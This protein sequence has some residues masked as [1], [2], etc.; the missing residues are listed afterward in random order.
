MAS[1]IRITVPQDVVQRISS[2]ASKLSRIE[3]RKYLIDI[4]VYFFLFP[5]LIILSIEFAQCHILCSYFC[6]KLAQRANKAILVTRLT[7]YHRLTSSHTLAQLCY[8]SICNYLL[9][10]DVLSLSLSLSFLSGERLWTTRR[11]KNRELVASEI[12]RRVSKTIQKKCRLKE[13]C[14]IYESF[15]KVCNVT[16]HTYL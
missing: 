10:L 13:N 16:F 11:R 1:R 9:R 2:T 7:Q 8:T 6:I 5:K 12:R 3:A 15:C 14:L 4:Y